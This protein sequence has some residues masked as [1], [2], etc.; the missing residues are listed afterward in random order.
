MNKVKTMDE[1][2]RPEDV[3]EQVKKLLPLPRVFEKIL[4]GYG[5]HRGR[6]WE[7]EWF[8]GDPVIRNLAEMYLSSN[9]SEITVTP[10]YL[11]FTR[12]NP[13][14]DE[15]WELFVFGITENGKLFLNTFGDENEEIIRKEYV[16]HLGNAELYTSSDDE[17]MYLVFCLQGFVPDGATLST[18]E[19]GDTKAFRLQGDVVAYIYRSEATI[20]L[21]LRGILRWG[22]ENSLNKYLRLYA[23]DTIYAT[24]LEHGFTPVLNEDESIPYFD[25]LLEGIPSSE[26]GQHKHAFLS[27]LNKYF[28]I[29]KAVSPEPERLW[30]DLKLPDFGVFFT[31]FTALRHSEAD[32]VGIIVHTKD[33]N[34]SPAAMRLRREF[35]EVLPTALMNPPKP[36]S[37]CIGNHRVT[38]RN[39]ISSEI[40]FR[41]SFRPTFFDR[42]MEISLTDGGLLRFISLPNASIT[43]E[44]KEHGAK[45]VYVEPYLALDLRTARVS[46][47]FPR[48]RNRAVLKA[49]GERA[50]KMDG[51]HQPLIRKVS[52]NQIRKAYGK[53]V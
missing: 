30:I 50:R 6:R 48:Y 1:A 26:F 44:H 22:F 34:N 45:T 21:D 32:R 41:P 52:I 17:V 12:T 11:V 28:H 9:V 36:I 10:S 14:N 53:P 51:R 2:L 47:N 39:F 23:L 20:D 13:E 38:L 24:L 7:L 4:L 31:E 37:F 15:E 5:K 19:V 35:E 18:E 42:P 29:L 8:D 3:V 33:V 16:C 43:L 49:L 27:I 40:T 46:R 25:L